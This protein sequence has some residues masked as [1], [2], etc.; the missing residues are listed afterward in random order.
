MEDLEKE[1]I[2]RN[3][4]ATQILRYVSFWPVI[5]GLIIISI[6]ISSLYL[7][8]AEYYYTTA[9]KIEIIDKAQDS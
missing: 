7:R 4:L 2:E 5:T 3:R 8:Y 9:A 6:I 1:E